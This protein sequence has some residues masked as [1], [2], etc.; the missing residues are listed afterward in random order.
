MEQ[1]GNRIATD[2]LDEAD[3]RYRN[4]Q[5][6]HTDNYSDC[7]EL[8]IEADPVPMGSPTP[9]TSSLRQQGADHPDGPARKVQ[10]LLNP[11]NNDSASA[12]RRGPASPDNNYVYYKALLPTRPTALNSRIIPGRPRP[13]L[14][15]PVNNHRL[16]IV[17]QPQHVRAENDFFL[18]NALNSGNLVPEM[19]VADPAR[20]RLPKSN[21]QREQ[22]IA[23]WMPHIRQANPELLNAGILIATSN[24]AFTELELMA[25]QFPPH[26]YVHV[27][28]MWTLT[29]YALIKIPNNLRYRQRKLQAVVH[30]D[31]QTLYNLH[32]ELLMVQY[33]LIQDIQD[34]LSQ[35]FRRNIR[36]PHANHV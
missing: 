32:R 9:S 14:P 16:H 12:I 25:L 28:E 36:I 1:A 29:E 8:V 3:R 20:H 30:K 2:M 19:P 10:R 7:E 4:Q 15:P 5:S 17:P 34:T 26:Q 31:F 11:N 21:L 18:R 23:A 13:V 27:M 35:N 22:D 33:N 6:P 24:P